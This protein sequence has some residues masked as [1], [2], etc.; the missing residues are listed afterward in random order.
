[1]AHHSGVCLDEAID[2]MGSE[3]AVIVPSGQGQ[4]QHEQRLASWSAHVASWLAATPTPLLVSYERLSADPAAVLAE[5]ATHCGIGAAPDAVAR[6]VDANRF[7]R[8]QA[9]ERAKG[10]RLG[11]A[12]GR[13]FFRRGVAGGWR[14]TLSATQAERILRDH[15]PMM[16]QLGYL[17]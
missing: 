11:Q 17:R 8:L 2:F 1:M 7:D 13:T 15:G 10:F 3:T 16:K 14:D 9:E 4:G 5:V 12:E 6:A